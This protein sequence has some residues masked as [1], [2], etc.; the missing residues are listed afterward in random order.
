MV[1]TVN[2]Q[3]ELFLFAII[4]HCGIL[5][6]HTISLQGFWDPLR[7]LCNW[8]NSACG[9]YNR[10]KTKSA[11]RLCMCVCVSV[12]KIKSLACDL[13]RLHYTKYKYNI[14]IVIYSDLFRL[15][16]IGLL[17]RRINLSIIR[18]F[19]FSIEIR[20]FLFLFVLQI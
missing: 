19:F 13:L 2:L 20:K 3:R 12:W 18:G 14:T 6:I 10:D 17:F 4:S 15:P 1:R 5:D 7:P 9:A 8:H 16:R 11:F